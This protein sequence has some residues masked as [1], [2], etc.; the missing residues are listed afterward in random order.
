MILSVQAFKAEQ[1]CLDV[2]AMVEA[3]L[4]ALQEAAVA[5]EALVVA[6]ALRVEVEAEAAA[7]A[8]QVSDHGCTGH[9]QA[10]FTL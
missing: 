8:L 9:H 4:G 1:P 2:V 6:A 7:G 3:G 10:S 5:A